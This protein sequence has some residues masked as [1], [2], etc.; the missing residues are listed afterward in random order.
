MLCFSR[1]LMI[2]L[3]SGL[4]TSISVRSSRLGC[5]GSH[6]LSCHKSSS[7]P[8]IDPI[9]MKLDSP[10]FKALFTPELKSLVSMFE[11]YNYEIRIAGGAVRDLLMG[12]APKDL[13][14][15]TV[16]TP[17]QMRE[18]FTKEEVRMINQRGESH[19]T[20]T[21]RIN[22]KENFEVTTLRIDVETDG[23]HAKV[24]FTE[25]WLLDA[26]RRD[27]TINS[28]FLGL[29]GTVYDYFNGYEDLMNK[30]VL[31]VG[32]AEDRIRE[33]YLRILRYFRFF[34]RIA[35]DPHDYDAE[36]I[37]VIS[38]NLEGLNK[39]AGERI[40][41][42]LRLIISGNSGPLILCK[43]LEIGIAPYIGLP[44]EHN[45][46]EL[47]YVIDRTKDFQ[48]NPVSY[49]AAVLNN[50]SEAIT[51]NS[52]LKLSVFERE[53]AYFI[54]ANRG[55]EL[56]EKPL[57]PFQKLMLHTKFKL[58]DVQQ[59]CVETLRYNG[60]HKLAEEMKEWTMP[61]LPVTGND[62]KDHVTQTKKMALVVRKLKDYWADN[63]YK[64]GTEELISIVPKILEEA[65]DDENRIAKKKKVS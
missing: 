23:R 56:S 41:S 22:D 26:N 21:P 34:G 12:K 63:D 35:S 11:K 61:R 2:K 17:D 46:D 49:L 31:F 52:R 38:S 42:E 37:N 30:R 10:E 64:P 18:M 28:M 39:I 16:A 15:A 9:I 47:H 65:N 19:G 27:L 24:V 3:F 1:K 20:I 59:W 5:L 13:D 33:D 14:F 7:K 51:L 25:D 43:M 62:L 36:T 58:S 6:V 60:R 4:S 29:D 32:N 57:L 45:M 48:L 8:R 53:L 50:M 40:W 44:K 55:E 54:V